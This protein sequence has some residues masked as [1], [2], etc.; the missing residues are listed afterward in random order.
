MR[1]L[2]VGLG[3]VTGGSLPHID[4][5]HRFGRLAAEHG[6]IGPSVIVIDWVFR[7]RQTGKITVVQPP[8]VLLGIFVFAT[9]VRLALGPSGTARAALSG[10]GEAALVLWALDE[11]VR[12]VNPWR[13]TL[14]AGILGWQVF[15]LLSG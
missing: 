13:R 1:W 10:I 2:G 7:S 8:N 9:V 3:L 12:G 15:S 14:G 4:F 6:Y 5:R 11:L